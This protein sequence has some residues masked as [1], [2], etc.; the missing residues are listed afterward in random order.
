VPS[1][2]ATQRHRQHP[3]HHRR[4]FE[5]Y[6]GGLGVT[7]VYSLRCI[8]VALSCSAQLPLVAQSLTLLPEVPPY[9]QAPLSSS[10]DYSSHSP[11]PTGTDPLD[12]RKTCWGSKAPHH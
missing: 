3:R 1:L 7:P 8:L 5:P 6:I 9:L 2:D 10:K 12:P 11:F 4:A